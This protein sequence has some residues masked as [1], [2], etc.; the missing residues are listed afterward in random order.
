[1]LQNQGT[2]GNPTRQ[3]V[4]TVHKY[5]Q[6]QRFMPKEAGSFIVTRF[7]AGVELA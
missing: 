3:E 1:M 7:D 5:A 6:N 2:H 4:K